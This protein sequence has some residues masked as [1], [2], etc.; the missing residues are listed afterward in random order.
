MRTLSKIAPIALLVGA[1]ILSL[2]PP[3]GADRRIKQI[4]DPTIPDPPGSSSDPEVP[5]QAY[6]GPAFRLTAERPVELGPCPEVR[7]VLSE[8]WYRRLLQFVSAQFRGG[9][10]R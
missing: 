3:A 1:L 9:G 5:N 10:V 2:S 8:A 4:G 7:A 6:R